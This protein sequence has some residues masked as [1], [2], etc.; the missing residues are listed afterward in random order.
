MNFQEFESI[1][2]SRGFNTLAEISRALDSTPQAVSNWKARDQVPHYIVNK[3]KESNNSELQQI[4]NTSLFPLQS[5]D[6]VLSMSDILVTMA[7]QL[8]VILFI[9]FVAGFIAFTYIQFIQ[10]PK[11]ISSARVLIP[12]ANNSPNSGIAGFASQFGVNVGQQQSKDLSSPALFP[13]ILKSRSFGEKLLNKDFYYEKIGKKKPLLNILMENNSDSKSDNELN[14]TEAISILA[15]IIDFI[16][17]LS[18]SI[19]TVE[20]TTNNAVFSKDLANAVLDELENWNRFY[21][22]QSIIKKTSFIENRIESVRKELEISEVNL[23]KFNEQNRQISSPALQLQ[24]DRLTRDVEVQKGIYLTLKQQ[25]E[26]AK[27]EV[28]QESSIIQI[29]DRPQIPLGPSNK[30]INIG[31]LISVLLGTIVGLAIAFLRNYF[32]NSNIDERKKIRR[33]R[34]FFNKPTEF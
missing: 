27:I 29:L 13:E 22:N 1:M 25:L 3:I 7:E 12:S 26:L 11:Y 24:L 16:P 14:I 32:T 21:K 4:N 9:P 23:K 34:N 2:A 15:G 28:I 10:Q 30:N 18:S 5:K 6:D 8:K 17:N 20:V 19:S 33:M 31:V